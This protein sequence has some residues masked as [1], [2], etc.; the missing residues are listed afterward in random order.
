MI[1]AI[2]AVVAMLCIVAAIAAHAV[3]A[4]DGAEWFGDCAYFAIAVAVAAS[5]VE[6]AWSEPDKERPKE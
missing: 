1:R 5:L 6:S 3:G 2:A 4:L